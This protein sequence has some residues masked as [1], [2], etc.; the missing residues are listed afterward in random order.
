MQGTAKC[1]ELQE[2]THE[3]VKGTYSSH[4]YHHHHL[5][6]TLIL[7]WERAH[8]GKFPNIL[9]SPALRA[10]L[11]LGVKPRDL[12]ELTL[13]LDLDWVNSWVTAQ[14]KLYSKD[15]S[16]AV[17]VGWYYVCNIQVHKLLNMK[18]GVR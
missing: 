6:S 1:F 9:S 15:Y 4:I 8:E 14:A 5:M 17:Q 16:G 10:L 12:Q 18:E 3:Q 11:Q 2:R 13:D 7:A